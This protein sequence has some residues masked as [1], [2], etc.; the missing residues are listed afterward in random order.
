[1][2]IS[3]FGKEK[4]VL[5]DS[6]Q[7]FEF[8]KFDYSIFEDGTGKITIDS[9]L[10][11][12]YPFIQQ[13]NIS[14]KAESRSSYYW[15]KLDFVDSSSIK[16][17][18][19]LE[20]YHNKLDHVEFYSIDHHHQIISREIT[21]ESLTFE[22]KKIQHKNFVFPIFH[23]TGNKI[24]VYLRLKSSDQSGFY[25][26]I[27]STEHFMSYAFTE[28]MHLG[29]F[30][31]FLLSVL[32]Y[33]L[34]IFFYLRAPEYIYYFSYVLSFGFYSA[35]TDGMGFQFLWSD[36]P[37]VNNFLPHAG[38]CGI[39][40]FQI[41]FGRAFNDISHRLPFLDKIIWTVISLRLVYFL[42]SVTI[43]PN[44]AFYK[45]IDIA[46]IVLL[47]AIGIMSYMKGY[48]LALFYC[49]G[50]VI[51]FIGFVSTMLMNYNIITNVF[52]VYALN[53]SILLEIVVFSLCLAYRFK[54]MK[55]QYDIAEK[56]MALKTREFKIIERNKEILERAVS[57]RTKKIR[58]Q[59]D[60]LQKKNED[61]DT[62]LYKSSHN[63]RGPIKSIEGLCNLLLAET[64][65]E[66][67]KKYIY[68]IQDSSYQLDHDLLNLRIISEL[69]TKKIQ[70]R[71]F[72]V[73]TASEKVLVEQNFYGLIQLKASGED[74]FCTDEILFMDF[75]RNIINAA[76][77][78]NSNQ[79]PES[80]S[81]HFDVQPYEAIM[82]VV[83]KNPIATDSF[84]TE[85]FKPFN[86][87][88]KF[89]SKIDFELY[90]AKLVI[91]KLNGSLVK[92]THKSEFIFKIVLAPIV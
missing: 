85:L 51:F 80:I 56:R 21:G 86:I 78:L 19:V 25:G 88:L 55:I 26:R 82:K 70:A 75:F 29:V 10:T 9:I 43:F 81:I 33:N 18:W 7:E 49:I 53:I 52:T 38:F 47:F 59:K 1:M 72:N 4:I 36:F 48:K 6:I 79:D 92:E 28:Y 50:V 20:L 76:L 63:L 61:L 68:L 65:P 83:I 13:T 91:E 2:P 34:I 35:V 16:K 3:L 77:K 62:F 17:S 32:L 64:D 58:A 22:H 14:P 5:K 60:L 11:K 12:E 44:L 31:G 24:T 15:L 42:L 23:S 30:Y 27:R 74:Q 69:N 66:Q 67:R 37:E 45:L 46:S 73:I 84:E 39:I 90:R 8:T 41:L 57:S 54:D 87:N 71:N 89:K 40:I